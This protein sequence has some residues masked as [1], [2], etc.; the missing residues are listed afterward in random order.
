MIQ[1]T[2]RFLV[3]SAVFSLLLWAIALL[4]GCSVEGAGFTNTGQPAKPV[5]CKEVHPGYTRCKNVD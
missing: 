3:W 4:A 1:E 5:V 2:L